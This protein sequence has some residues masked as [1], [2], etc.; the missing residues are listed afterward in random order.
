MNARLS[1]FVL[2]P[3]GSTAKTFA[4]DEIVSAGDDVES[5]KRNLL[6]RRPLNFYLR[7]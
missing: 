2:P 4:R 1:T 7:H 5:V 3:A 6:K